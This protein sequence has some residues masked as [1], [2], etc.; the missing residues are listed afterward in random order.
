[1]KLNQLRDNI[2][3]RKNRKRVGRGAGS[4]TGET[5]GRGVKGQKSRSGVAI[6]GF[7]GGQ[8][9][10]HMRLPK[11]GFVKPNAKKFNV[12]TLER[13]QQAITAKKINPAKTITVASLKEAGVIRR[14]L[15]GVRLLAKGDFKTKITIELAG[16]SAS[17]RA[18]VEKLGGKV[19][20]LTPKKEEAPKKETAKK[21][22][23]K[24]EAATEPAPKE[25]ASTEDNAT[26]PAPEKQE[27]AEKEEPAK[28]SE[29]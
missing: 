10:I 5:A 17:A 16:I 14:P 9:P 22:A 1:M 2:G 12:L 7:E 4:G 15:D 6:K 21:K 3:A 29:K 25:E 11:R 28:D 8:M 13:L 23:P 24:K 27:K 18:I 26:E 19:E 20:L